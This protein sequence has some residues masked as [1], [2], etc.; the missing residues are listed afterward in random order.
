MKKFLFFLVILLSLLGKLAEAQV[1]ISDDAS[2][3]PNSSAL[4]DIHSK[5]GDMGLLIP[6]VNLT[7]E[8]SASPITNPANGISA[9]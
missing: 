7:S 5:N 4:L 9:D 6:Q 1:A 8:T 3:T 2:Y